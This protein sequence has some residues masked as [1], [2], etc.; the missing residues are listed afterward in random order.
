LTVVID[1]VSQVTQLD[2]PGRLSKPFPP[3]LEL[4]VVGT[5]GLHHGRHQK[6]IVLPSYH[7]SLTKH[8]EPS[9]LKKELNSKF[10]ERYVE[11]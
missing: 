3:R 4:I 5:L 1:D 10:K 2:D 11:L 8:A 6:V 9:V 7:V